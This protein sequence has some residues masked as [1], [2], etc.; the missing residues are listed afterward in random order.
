MSMSKVPADKQDFIKL[1]SF[2]YELVIL[3]EHI[4]LLCLVGEF[5]YSL[6]SLGRCI[7]LLLSPLSFTVRATLLGNGIDLNS[8][9]INHSHLPI[10][11]KN[12]CCPEPHTIISSGHQKPELK[13][14]CWNPICVPNSSIVVFHELPSCWSHL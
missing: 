1:S 4:F 12:T 6:I 5:N 7:Q 14:T 10:L 13:C 2:T 8:S 9:I 3:P 11:R